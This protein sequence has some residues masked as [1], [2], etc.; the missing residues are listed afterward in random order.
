MFGD[1]INKLALEYFD[2]SWW[3]EVWSLSGTQHSSSDSPWTRVTV[4]LAT[5]PINKLRFLGMTGNNYRGDIAI[6]EVR[7]ILEGE[8]TS[9]LSESVWTYNGGDIYYEAGNVGIGTSP[10]AKLD[11]KGDLRV[12]VICDGNGGNCKNISTGWFD[13]EDLVNKLNLNL[14]NDSQ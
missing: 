4:D 2:G 3:K 11:I 10:Q 6:D 5:L 13:Y 12:E 9:Q 14:Y 7:I 8:E 1:S